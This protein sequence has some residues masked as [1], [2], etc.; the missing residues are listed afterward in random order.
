M[1]LLSQN[2]DISEKLQDEDLPGIKKI[3]KNCKINRFSVQ[4]L[5]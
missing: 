4:F 5:I 2:I 1:M 3:Y